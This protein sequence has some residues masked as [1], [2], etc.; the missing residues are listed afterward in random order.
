DATVVK[1]YEDLLQGV[2]FDVQNVPETAA[3]VYPGV[4]PGLETYLR[5]MRRYSPGYAGNALS[6]DG[7]E[8]A[9]LMVAGIKAAG[10]HLTQAALVA[11]TNRLSDFTSG[12]LE[13]PVDWKTAHFF[14]TRKS[15]TAFEEVKGASVAPVLGRG[16][17]VFLCFSSTHVRH[18]DPVAPPPGIPGPHQG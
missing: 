2:Y 9:A 3:R 8:S 12:G 5:A 15:C 1:K 17:Q 13:E 11:S 18:P 4:Y 16:K 10:R 6:L 7:W 14:A